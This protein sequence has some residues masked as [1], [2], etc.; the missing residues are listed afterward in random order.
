M[1][2]FILSIC[3]Q[4]NELELALEGMRGAL[5]QQ[6]EA[7]QDRDA[8]I[9]GLEAKIKQQRTDVRRV[10]DEL[11]MMAAQKTTVRNLWLC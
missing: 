8:I 10:E 1:L 4:K 5:K 6:Q 9:V 2:N 7:V 3:L 11:N